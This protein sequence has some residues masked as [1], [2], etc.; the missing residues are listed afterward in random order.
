MSSIFSKPCQQSPAV[1]IV[2]PPTYTN[3]YA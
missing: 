2:S 3:F 1:F